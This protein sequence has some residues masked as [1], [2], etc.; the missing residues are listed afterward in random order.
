MSSVPLMT[1]HNS[2]R[3][4]DEAHDS[5]QVSEE[6]DDPLESVLARMKY[7]PQNYRP[8]DFWSSVIFLGATC[9]VIGF[10]V[11]YVLFLTID[12]N[13][14]DSQSTEYDVNFQI[15]SAFLLEIS[16]AS[17]SN[18]LNTTRN[19]AQHNR[20]LKLQQ[21]FLSLGFDCISPVTPTEVTLSY[22]D[23][24][25]HNLVTVIDENGDYRRE[26]G[27]ITGDVYSGVQGFSVSA[28]VNGTVVY[29]NFG[30]ES[31]FK[32]LEALHIGIEKSILLARLGKVP[33][34][35]LVHRC[36]EKGAVGVILFA[37]PQQYPDSNKRNKP[38]LLPSHL[39]MLQNMHG[40]PATEGASNGLCFVGGILVTDLCC[41]ILFREMSSNSPSPDSWKGSMSVSYQ[42]GPGF[43]TSNWKLKMQTNMVNV[44]KTYYSVSGAIRGSHE[45]DR[46]V[47]LGSSHGSLSGNDNL[48][49]T[50]SMM[51]L[52]R[53]FSVLSSDRGWRP[54]RSVVFCSWG[55]NSLDASVSPVP[56][57]H[58]WGHLMQQRAVAYLDLD[59]AV[60]GN[61][62]LHIEATP[63]L[64]NTIYNASSLMLDLNLSSAKP[65]MLTV[66][67][68]WLR[69]ADPKKPKVD[70]INS[71]GN[72]QHLLNDLG[73]PSLILHFTNTEV[74]TGDEGF[75]H[76]TTVAKLWALLTWLLADS[77]IVP[78]DARQ[79]A[80]FLHDSMNAVSTQYEKYVK[81]YALQLE[82]AVQ[83]FTTAAKAFQLK[84]LHVDKSNHV[85]NTTHSSA[86]SMQTDQVLTTRLAKPDRRWCLSYAH[87]M[88]GL[89][90]CTISDQIR[91]A[92]SRREVLS[93]Y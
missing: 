48:G 6:E 12:Q 61:R 19:E 41:V 10:V 73:V 40:N 82:S 4:S 68:S 84:L 92:E 36:L 77:L 63:L 1:L 88:V 85:Q 93:K 62:S 13:N 8:I 58:D 69:S 67:D 90:V 14:R 43:S 55:F 54:W 24:N 89:S 33:P 50:A 23:I 34:G 27:G 26:F 76:H 30:R 49:A 35:D 9:F 18:A 57:I 71:E 44:K 86:S 17:I 20:A 65:R 15:A 25:K 45:P 87:W 32:Y 5:D 39:G 52:A 83:N 53:V 59:V 81:A 51:E 70:I 75:R 38:F 29:I 47:L 72:A 11:S 60:T 31:D 64:F 79:Y 91:S 74:C 78:F 2:E 46:Y 80:L 16:A 28:A 37:D 66:V 21:H 42:I 56:L 7:R 22:Y 3:R